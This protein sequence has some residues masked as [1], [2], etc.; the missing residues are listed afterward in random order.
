MRTAD[1]L[2]NYQRTLLEKFH[3]TWENLSSVNDRLIYAH[4]T[5]YGDSGDDADDPAFD[6]LAIGRVRV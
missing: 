6:A 5:G 3:L 2:T 1:V 4:L